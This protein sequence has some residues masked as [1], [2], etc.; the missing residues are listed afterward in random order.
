MHPSCSN[1]VPKQGEIP[2]L[3]A[4]S[5][6]E[7]QIIECAAG[8]TNTLIGYAK[9]IPNT[10]KR[11]RNIFIKS[12]NRRPGNK[13]KALKATLAMVST[14]FMGAIQL[15]MIAA[16]PLPKYKQGAPEIKNPG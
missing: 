10:G 5:S 9:Q 1:F 8:T 16:Q 12:Y 4:Y 13:M 7:S 6:K 15:A 14:T 11:D 2:C 3:T